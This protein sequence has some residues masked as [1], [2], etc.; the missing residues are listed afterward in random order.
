MALRYKFTNLP[1]GSEPKP[2]YISAQAANNGDNRNS[3]ED[4][5]FR[6]SKVHIPAHVAFCLPLIP[7][8]A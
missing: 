2:T 7:T 8:T 3:G 6:E 5:Q 1:A 4:N